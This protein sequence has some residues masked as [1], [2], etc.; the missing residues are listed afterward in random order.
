MLAAGGGGDVISAS[1]LSRLLGI[2]PP[3]PVLTYSWDRL[4]VDPLPGPRFADNFEGL[5][6]LAPNVLEVT[7]QPALFRRRA[8]RSPACPQSCRFELCS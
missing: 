1:L 2:Q 6:Q 7:P 5:T 8:R 4:L 3:A